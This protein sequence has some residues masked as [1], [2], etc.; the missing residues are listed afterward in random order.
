MSFVA[1][2]AVSALFGLA[3]CGDGDCYNRR[4]TPCVQR[5]QDNLETEP[6]SC[7]IMLQQS[8]C[9]LSAAIDCQMGFIMKAQQADEYLRKVCEDK[10]KYFRDNQECF[11]IAVKDRKCHAPIEK[12][13][14]NRTTR[15]EVLKAMNETCVEVFWFERCITSSVEDDCG[16]NKLDIFKTVFT[17]LVNLYVAY[18]KEVVIPADKNSDQYFTFGLPSIFELIVDIFHY[19]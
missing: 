19:D 15:K 13:M 17:P 18:C 1:L 3:Y 14:S 2:L 16:K 12:I 10:L 8:K 9:V 11:S 7:P 4:V 5:I 6:D